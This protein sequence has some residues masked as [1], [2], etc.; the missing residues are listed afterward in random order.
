MTLPGLKILL[1]L[2]TPVGGLWRSK[3]RNLGGGFCDKSTLGLFGSK[4]RSVWLEGAVC[5]RANVGSDVHAE[6]ETSVAAFAR[7][8]TARSR[9]GP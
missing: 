2:G 7:V 3:N 8:A 5:E 1:I 9:G 6:G 4:V